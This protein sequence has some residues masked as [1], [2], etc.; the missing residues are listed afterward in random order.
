MQSKFKIQAYIKILR[1]LIK[2]IIRLEMYN[3]IRQMSF[4]GKKILM[5]LP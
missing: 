3:L 2:T 4:L 5:I 1:Y